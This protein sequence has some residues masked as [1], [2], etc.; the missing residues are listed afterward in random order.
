MKRGLK[1]LVNDTIKPIQYILYTH[2]IFYFE[3]DYIG[4]WG[5]SCR[6]VHTIISKFPQCNIK[7]GKT[8]EKIDWRKKAESLLLGIVQLG[9]RR[10]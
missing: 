1:P 3:K 6:R 9:V 7:P 10:G 5:S 2:S 8:S 4:A